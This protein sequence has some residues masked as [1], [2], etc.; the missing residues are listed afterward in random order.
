MSPVSV[1]CVLFLSACYVLSH[2]LYIYI[3]LYIFIYIY[4]SALLLQ[5]V[6][7]GTL[8]RRKA[9]DARDFKRRTQ[10]LV[11]YVVMFQRI[12]RGNQSRKT[13]KYVADAIRTMYECRQKEAAVGCG[14][15]NDWLIHWFI[16][17][18][19][20]GINWLTDISDSLS[21]SLS[22]STLLC[23]CSCEVPELQSSSPSQ[24]ENWRLA[25]TH[26]PHAPRPEPGRH[27]AAMPCALCSR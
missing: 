26:L 14:E 13:Y 5:R 19:I 10:A 16:D 8:G 17:C 4:I 24:V 27:R 9:E 11:P 25:R 15:L 3:N 22:T 23:L 7:R 2:G 20:D 6:W 1:S 12:Y 21:L 18:L